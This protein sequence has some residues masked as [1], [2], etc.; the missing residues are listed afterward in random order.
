MQ[1]VSQAAGSVTLDGACSH[2]Q[3]AVTEVSVAHCLDERTGR[4]PA[5]ADVAVPE[6]IASRFSGEAWRQL[7][8][9]S[10]DLREE[11]LAYLTLPGENPRQ[12][13]ELVLVRSE[14]SFFL[15][16]RE[17]SQGAHSLE[18][19]VKT[20]SILAQG[21]DLMVVTDN[22]GSLLSASELWRNFYG[23]HFRDVLG[24]NPRVINSGQHPPTLFQNMWKALTNRAVGT[25]SGEL[26]NRRRDGQLVNVW[27]TI[28]AVRDR[29]GTI[30]GYL[31]QTRDMTAHHES[32]RQL[33]RSLE[34]VE[35]LNRGK[36]E[37]LS[38]TAHDLRALLQVILGYW[39]LV[40]AHREVLTLDRVIQYVEAMGEA[41]ERMA[42]LIQGLSALHKAESDRLALKVGR[43]NFS[44]MLTSVLD[45]HAASARDRG[46]R[47]EFHQNQAALPVFVDAS[48]FDQ[49]LNVVI[50]RAVRRS[51]DHGVVRVTFRTESEEKI[52]LE[53]IDGGELPLQPIVPPLIQREPESGPAALA[54]NGK[55]SLEEAKGLIQLHDGAIEETVTTEG[56]NSIFMTFPSGWANYHQQ[57][58]A[59]VTYD[60]EQLISTELMAGLDRVGVDRFVAGAFPEFNLLCRRELPNIIFIEESVAAKL[61]IPAFGD[62]PK[63]AAL[64]PAEVVV[65]RN[66][67]GELRFAW[68]GGDSR[69]LQ[70]TGK[71][72][73]VLRAQAR[74]SATKTSGVAA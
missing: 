17:Q 49:I 35:H 8:R 60:P 66:E 16:M 62:T 30:V 47:L 24:R 20:F 69:L 58:W 32:R 15:M 14:R 36:S 54:T 3:W 40:K 38:V 43:A 6:T 27:Q 31:G 25:W 65:S 56:W 73:Q 21:S 34:A 44:A 59:A 55:Y 39:S 74:S 10:A 7:I 71:L 18:D 51:P 4:F 37:I 61:T 22:R 41:G 12:S 48:K 72:L 50:G 46:V 64:R 28:T 63:L 42:T 29:D 26:V 11:E 67:N 68:R 45:A 5:E 23:F 1:Q 2:G 52:A 57:I 13:L 70:P 53:V 33:V 19:L 9:R